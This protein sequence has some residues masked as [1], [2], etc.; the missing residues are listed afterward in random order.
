MRT[1]Q[2]QSINQG[3]FPKQ[4][5]QILPDKVI[6]P[7]RIKLVVLDQRNPHRTSFR[8]NLNMWKHLGNLYLVRTGSNRSSRSDYAYMFTPADAIHQFD[9][10]TDNTQHPAC[11]IPNGQIPLLDCP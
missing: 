7:G 9:R 6:G 11:F 3:I 4:F 10:R 8:S 5:I 1:T 2:D